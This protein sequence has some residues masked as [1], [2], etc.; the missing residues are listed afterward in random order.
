LTV[1]NEKILSISNAVRT[2]IITGPALRYWQ[3]PL[4]TLMGDLMKSRCRGIDPA[5]L[6]RGP[7]VFT[8]RNLEPRDFRA[9]Q[10]PDLNVAEWLQFVNPNTVTAVELYDRPLH[11]A[12][13][14]L[15]DIKVKIMEVI[16]D[17]KDPDLPFLL[18]NLE[19]LTWI[20]MPASKVKLVV[21]SRAD[22]PDLVMSILFNKEA[23]NDGR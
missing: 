4:R 21:N 19:G 12:R 5:D 1:Q 14:K 22:Q 23:G 13:I 17:D 2:Q 8:P 3:F 9:G 6:V 11:D 16:K 15:E 18:K 10:W 20:V 7:D